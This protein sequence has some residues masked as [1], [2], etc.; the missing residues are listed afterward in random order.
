MHI[1][2]LKAKHP[3]DESRD[4][5]LHLCLS[6]NHCWIFLR[7]CPSFIL[8]L[9]QRYLPSR[10]CHENEVSKRDLINAYSISKGSFYV[11]NCHQRVSI[12]KHTEFSVEKWDGTTDAVYEMWKK[13]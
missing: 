12:N 2:V 7:N 1:Y 5:L 11:A 3:G 6:V 9:Q 10:L 4:T 8:Q 13:K